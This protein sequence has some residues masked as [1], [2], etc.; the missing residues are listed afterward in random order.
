M[1][2]GR[3]GGG[4]QAHHKSIRDSMADV[5]GLLVAG[6]ADSADQETEGRLLP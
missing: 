3:R 5:V 6:G 4:Q 2:V 1:R